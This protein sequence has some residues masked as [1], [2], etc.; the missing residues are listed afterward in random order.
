MPL[1]TQREVAV[2]STCDNLV[3]ELNIDAVTARVLAARGIS[4]RSDV[5]LDLRGLVQPSGLTGIANAA[6]RVIH[7][8]TNNESIVIAGDFDADGATASALCVSFLSSVGAKR[9]SFEVPNR[10]SM[11]YGLSVPFV[12][13]LLTD[14][15]NLIITVDNGISS[16]DGVALAREHDVDVIVTD[17]HLPPKQLPPAHAIVN[18]Q[19]ESS[20]FPSQPSGVGV[21]FYLMAEV[22]RQLQKLQY[23]EQHQLPVPDMRTY[24]D[25]V[26]I[27]TVVD[28][29]PLDRNNRI[30]VKQGIQRI[31]SGATRPGIKLL[32]EK[33]RVNLSEVNEDTLGFRLGPRLNAAGRLKDI[34][35]GIKALLATDR[36]AATSYVDQLHQWNE[37]RQSL[38]SNMTEI[39]HRRIRELKDSSKRGLVMFDDRFHE[40]IVGLVANTIVQKLFRPTIVFAT[41]QGTQARLVK[42]SARSIPGVHIR[43][44]LANI[45][46][47]YPN[48]IKSFGGH[49]MAAGLTLQHA[50]LERF[51][52]IFDTTVAQSVP[53]HVFD[54]IELTDGELRPQNLNLELI[55]ELQAFGP[56]GQDFPPPLFHGTFK[57]LRQNL[58][59]TQKH[60]KLELGYGERVVE[61]IK[62]RQ[63]RTVPDSITITY[64]PTIN[65]YHRQPT[66]QLLIEKIFDTSIDSLSKALGNGRSYIN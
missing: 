56:W 49:A 7:A 50:S 47:S 61:A 2:P 34:S 17:H 32:C 55:E 22:K 36:K 26:A 19:L 51:S 20:D 31:R 43:D 53:R 29:V 5:A 23:F 62:F 4:A 54:Q 60:L 15:P 41:S 42:G 25:L 10:F 45:S 13:S 65:Y 33:C 6:A 27:G 58:I 16:V 28:L 8:I 39:A 12:V 3:S 59:G 14:K 57:V 46:S 11:G 38:Q 64:R 35:V 66:V 24:L 37:Q 1:L 21:A 48:L 40:G 63:D 18:P 52:N 9:V 44:V 30:L